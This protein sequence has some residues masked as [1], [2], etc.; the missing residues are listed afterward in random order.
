MADK[1]VYGATAVEEGLG[2]QNGIVM[3]TSSSKEVAKCRTMAS[4]ARLCVVGAGIVGIMAYVGRVSYKA[5]WSVRASGN[6]HPLQYV[7]SMNRT[8]SH[9]VTDSPGCLGAS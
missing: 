4:W 9:H 2:H 8:H 7:S 1:S 3:D 6:L 5:A